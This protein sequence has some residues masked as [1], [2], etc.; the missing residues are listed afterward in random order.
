LSLIDINDVSEPSPDAKNVNSAPESPAS[1]VG[2]GLSRKKGK[3]VDPRN[4]GNVDFLHEFTDGDFE[5]QRD[6][7]EI[8]A[9]I[10]RVLK[11][12]QFTT[13]PGFFDESEV[14]KTYMAQ[15]VD[16]VSEGDIC[17]LPR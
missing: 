9:E 2:E 12:E 16:P 10:N 13:P 5:A 15:D 11:W 7:L 17:C 6:A 1:S 4:W 3:G 8:F 14:V